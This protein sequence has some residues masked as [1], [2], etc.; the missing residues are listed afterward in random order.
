MDINCKVPKQE[1]DVN[2]IDSV[3]TLEAPFWGSMLNGLELTFNQ[4]K[5]V[6]EVTYGDENLTEI[7]EHFT[8]KDG[9]KLDFEECLELI[10]TKGRGF[11]PNLIFDLG[12]Q[13]LHPDFKRSLR[14]SLSAGSS[15]VERAFAMGLVLYTQYPQVVSNFKVFRCFSP[16]NGVLTY[17]VMLRTHSEDFIVLGRHKN[18][19]R[20]SLERL[21]TGVKKIRKSRVYSKVRYAEKALETALYLEN[22]NDGKGRLNSK[23]RAKFQSK[24]L[25]MES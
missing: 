21:K 24:T 5:G 10:N 13:V 19:Q 12:D 2:L 11:N 3:T 4:D 22:L 17:S 7:L 9:Q 23:L 14:K 6:Y 1:E 16:A 18:I 15:C 25:E 20:Y 8:H